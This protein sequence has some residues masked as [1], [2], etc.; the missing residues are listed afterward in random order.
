M[1]LLLL[2]LNIIKVCSHMPIFGDGLHVENTKSKSYGVYVSVEDSYSLTMN[3]AKGDNISFSLSVPDY[4]E[5]QP[6]LTVTLFGHGANDTVCDPEFNGWGTKPG[7]EKSRRRLDAQLDSTKQIKVRKTTEKVFEPF[8]VA[9]YRPIAACQ[10]K[11]VIGD[12][13]FRLTITN[14]GEEPVPISIGIGMAE[15]FDFFDILFMSFT[16]MQSWLWAGKYWSFVIPIAAVL[17]YILFLLGRTPDIFLFTSLGVGGK[18]E[19]YLQKI[20]FLCGLFMLV[21]AAQFSVHILY[22]WGMGL[23]ESTMWL[24]LLIH[25][26][27]PIAAYYAFHLYFGIDLKAKYGTIKHWGFG[28]VFIAY[29]FA[30]LW[31]SYCVPL[32]SFI[33]FFGLKLYYASSYT[34]LPTN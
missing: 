16:L 26:L 18:H 6:D 24:S 23:A 15:S 13:L 20:A 33:M 27:L 4:Y 34:I 32:L 17:W 3:V 28:L 30:L 29:T 8:G 2:F 5:K 11:A 1:I 7:W 22:T 19:D 31:Q 25:V 9:G 14:H 10:G 12:D 21:N